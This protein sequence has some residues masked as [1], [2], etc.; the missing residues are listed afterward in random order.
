MDER[1]GTPAHSSPDTALRRELLRPADAR[2][3]FVLA[4]A[5]ALLA[6]VLGGYVLRATTEPAADVIPVA[7]VRRSLVDVEERP[8]RPAGPAIVPMDE[9]KPA[10]L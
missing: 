6:G 10:P 5:T 9:G 3:P 8:C 2:V 7:P 1:T 4:L